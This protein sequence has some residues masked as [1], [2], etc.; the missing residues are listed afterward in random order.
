MSAILGLVP[1]GLMTG[2]AQL[3]HGP[4]GVSVSQ[5]THRVESCLRD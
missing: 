3:S 4:L 1:T 5:K 2:G